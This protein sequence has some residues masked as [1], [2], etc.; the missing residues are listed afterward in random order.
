MAFRAANRWPLGST[1]TSG[2]VSARL[3]HLSHVRIHVGKKP[4]VEKKV[5][6]ELLR[7]DNLVS[8]PDL[9]ARWS[10]AHVVRAIGT[11][12]SECSW[13]LSYNSQ[14]LQLMQGLEAALRRKDTDAYVYF[15][16]KSVR[17]GGFWLPSLTEEIAE[18]TAFVL[19]VGENSIGPWQM[20]EYYEALDKRVRS[21]DFPVILVLLEGQAAPGLPFLRQLQWIITADPASEQTLA[22]LIDAGSGERSR[23]RELWRFTAPYRGLAAM[24]EAD[25]EFFF[26]RAEKTVEVIEGLAAAPDKLPILIGNSGVGKSSLAQAGV[27]ASLMQD[28]SSGAQ[29]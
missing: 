22:R 9:F 29:S 14:D 1:A 26:G 23:P 21:P 20:L 17:A 13:F 24:T 27:L 7:L 15:A 10:H 19:L 25:S 16:P 18:A 28:I 5:R 12:C 4:H 11:W 2:S 8:N 6:V 3:L